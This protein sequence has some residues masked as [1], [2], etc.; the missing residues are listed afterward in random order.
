M[1]KNARA[2]AYLTNECI[3]KGTNVSGHFLQAFLRIMI[4]KKD[5]AK[6]T[7]EI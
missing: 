6:N 7:D 3:H 1:H 4:E 2:L 5:N